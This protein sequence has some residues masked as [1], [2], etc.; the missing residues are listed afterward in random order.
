MLV[1]KGL[2]LDLFVC[3]KKDKTIAVKDEWLPRPKNGLHARLTSD[4]AGTS[5]ANFLVIPEVR[6]FW[7]KRRSAIRGGGGKK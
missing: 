1:R 4:I 2:L 5:K 7:G 6:V 3:G